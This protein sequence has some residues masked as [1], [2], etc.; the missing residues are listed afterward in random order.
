MFTETFNKIEKDFIAKTAETK[1]F[2]K[3]YS[4]L[5]ND[6][7]HPNKAFFSSNYNFFANSCIVTL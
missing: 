5:K 7:T 1:K 2:I 6:L 4:A 3:D